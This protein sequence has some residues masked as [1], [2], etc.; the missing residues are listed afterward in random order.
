MK[1]AYSRKIK[2]MAEAIE[3][4]HKVKSESKKVVFTN[5]CFDILHMGHVRYL[6]EARDLGDFLVVGLNSDESI[7]K[8]KGPKRPIQDER[9]RAEVLAGLSFVDMVVLFSDETPLSLILA[10]RPD[11]L[12]KGGDWKLDEIV[13]AK[14]VWGWG[15]KVE[16]IPYLKGYSTSDVIDRI[17]KGHSS[18]G[19]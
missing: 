3:E 15:G 11:V 16:V 2:S 13:G 17:L 4:I 12:V 9:S 7:R 10:L 6:S 14:E 5:G 19:H 18:Q 8:I 1:L